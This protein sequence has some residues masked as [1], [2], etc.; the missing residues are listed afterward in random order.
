M[1]KASL[2]EQT[3]LSYDPEGDVLYISFGEPQAADDSDV[4]DEGVI[5]RLREGRI[6]GLTILNA[7]KK[8]LI[9]AGT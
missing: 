6:V 7:T 1:G 5:V 4:T 2:I 8:L 3:K 9:P